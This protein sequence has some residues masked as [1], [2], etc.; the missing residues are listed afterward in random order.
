MMRTSVQTKL[1]QI[2]QV[3]L[4]SV[5]FSYLAL[6]SNATGE[7]LDNAG[8][9]IESSINPVF[10]N[11]SEPQSPASPAYPTKIMT[12]YD[13]AIR[14]NI[15]TIKINKALTWKSKSA[16]LDIDFGR[17]ESES[18][19]VSLQ[20]NSNATPLQSAYIPRLTPGTYS[21]LVKS[22]SVKSSSSSFGSIFN[23]LS[24]KKGTRYV[25]TWSGES[26]EIKALNIRAKLQGP[27]DAETGLMDDTLRTL[28]LIPAMEP[29]FL[30]GWGGDGETI[31]P[32]DPNGVL[33][34]TGNN[35]IVDWI[36]VQLYDYT[37]DGYGYVDSRSA[38]LQRD[39]DIVDINGGPVQFWNL[40]S[41][42]EP[43]YVAIQ[44]RNHSTIITEY[45]HPIGASEPLLDFT[46]STTILFED[47]RN[48]S[49]KLENGEWII[50]SGDVIRNGAVDEADSEAAL[51]ARG[52]TGYLFEDVN[53]DGVCD[54]IDSD[55]I[56]ENQGKWDWG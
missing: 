30:M 8:D 27:Y 36:K 31:D 17:W 28:D 47:S 19:F 40:P 15:S 11:I 55:I 37:F 4:L 26:R 42:N 20:Q 24:R 1:I 14:K 25:I 51:D 46:L 34:V 49:R 35:A 39:G 53:L 41:G 54:V 18:N 43:Y 2:P 50:W 38:L 5:F 22:K 33:T 6:A 44:H 29:Y 12:S 21:V 56:L 32:T 45:P 13:W 23:F 10:Q 7:E 9:Y 3:F 48:P 16:D 52:Q